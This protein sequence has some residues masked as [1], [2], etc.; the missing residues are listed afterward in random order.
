MFRCNPAGTGCALKPV[1]LTTLLCILLYAFPA[2]AGTTWDGGGAN[3]LWSTA[4]NWNPDGVPANNGTASLAFAGSTRLAPDMDANWNINSL[5]FNNGAGAFTLSSTGGFVL[6]IQ[7]GGITNNSASTETIN[8]AITLGAAQT[9]GATSGALSFGGNITTGGFLLT[10]SGVSN[11]AVNGVISGTGGLAKTGAGTLSLSGTNTY[12]GGTT[13]NAGA[14]S[15]SSN[16]NLGAA[17]GGLT[18]NGGTLDVTGNVVGTR[19][20]TMTG[21]G[22]F[23]VALG[24]S[25]EQSG[26]VSGNGNLTLTSFGTLILSGSGSNGTGLTSIGGIL[27]LRGTVT[28]GTGNLSFTTGVLELGNGNFT[29]ALGA[30]AGQ[31]NMSTATNGAGFAAYGT[32]RIVNLGGAGAIVTWGSGSFLA[33]GQVLYL[34]SLTSDH[35]VDFQNGINLNGGSRSIQL[36]A[37]VGSVADGKLSGVISG[38]GASNLS[39][40]AV[41][42]YGA[43]SVILSNGGNSYAGT[44]TV[45][46][47]TLILEASASG[48]AGNTVLGSGASDVLIGN[49]TGA[50]DAGLVTNNAVTVSRILRAQSGNTGVVTIGGTSASTSTFSGSL[51]LGTNAGTGKGVTLTSAAGGTTTFS[52]VVQDPTGVVGPGLVRTNGSGTVVLS[53]V[54][55]YAGGTSIDGGTLSIS[56]SA[57]L[58]ANAGGIAINAGTLSITSGFSTNR[59]FTLGNTASTLL[60]N[61]AQTLTITSAVGGTGALNKNGGGT[62]TL[63]GANTYTGGSIINGGTLIITSNGNLG[64]AAGAVTLNAAT[65]DV[66]GTFVSTRNFT[67]GSATSTVQVDPTFTF[68]DSGIF[69]G[70]GTLN[71]TGTGTLVLGG[72]NTY[73]G[74]TNVT[75]G[76]LRNGIANVIPD[77]SAVTVTSGATY[78]LNSFS[79]TVGSLSGAGTVTSGV[80]GTPTLTAGGENTSTLFSG[81]LQ[82]GSGTVSFTKSGT[83]T[84]TLSGANTYSG[85]T[86][87]SGGILLIQNSAALGTTAGGTTVSSG[88][89]LELQSNIAVAAEPLTLNGSGVSSFGAL[90]NLS[91]NN[92]LA[93]T[94]TLAS[95]STIYSDSGTLTLTGGIANG[96]FTVTFG[97]AGNISQTNPVSGTGALVKNDSGTLTLGGANTY[98]G[99]TTINGGT[100]II[101]STGNLGNTLGTATINAATLEAAATFTSSRNFILGS[102]TSTVQVDPT[103]TFTATGIISGAG[104]LNKTGA[105]TMVLSGLNLFS[106]GTTVTA[107]TLQLSAVNRLLTT[108]G[109]TISGGTFDLQTFGQTTSSVTLSSGAITGSGGGTLTGSSYTLQ[110]GTV[111]AILAGNGTLTKNTAG[112]VTLSGANTFTGSTTISAGL[113]Q[114]NTNNALGTTASGTTVANGAA[115]QLNGVNYSTAEPLTLNGSGI[116]NGGALT[117]TG[118]STF[119]GPINAATNATINAGGG[120]LTLTGGISKNGTTLTIAGGGTV[121]ITANGITGAAANSDLIVD[122]TTVVLSAASSY[123]GPTTIQN[124]GTLKL[125]NSNVLPTAPQTALTINTSSTLDLASF[126]GSVASLTGDSTATVKNSVIGGTST[127]TITPASGLT[128]FAGIIAGTNGGAQGN[129]ALQ[130]TGAGTLVLTGANT[131]SGATTVSGGTLTLAAASGSALASTS[132]LTVNSGGTLL[133]GASNQINNTATITLAGGT[134]AKGNFSE[135]SATAP[136]IGMGTL[137]L[138][139]A[140]SQIDFGSGTTGV[141]NFASFNPG[142]YALMI[143][144]WTGTPN[145]AGN[146]STDRLIFGSDQ[147]A[148]LGNFVFSGFA[149]GALEINLGN[150]YYEITPVPETSTWFAGAFILGILALRTIRRGRARALFTR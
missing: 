103:F 143:A 8:N 33:A 78:D 27:S 106:G 133:L 80:A 114:V 57:N 93:G 150:G 51:F 37:G 19:A 87:V 25:M 128:T 2:L 132:S 140:G 56:Q 145:V 47:G 83:G 118:T 26:V 110:S 11:T 10:I 92:S 117:N 136:G 130:K 30:G 40:D 52:G 69:S 135:G 61:P 75:A 41:P 46:A 17:S 101:T 127:L 3:N 15:I 95:A 71:K 134:F 66:A 112:T 115:L 98:S 125:G 34:G 62:L 14:V 85:L 139:A 79:E 142:T 89:T 18:F 124:S 38:T 50:Y 20:V 24:S 35:T 45:N 44:T 1:R 68:T 88:A 16:G 9:W 86:T 96:G 109:L 63:G 104:T 141:L 149:P 72:D 58:G 22:T 131:L 64:A 138:T 90:R 5:T 54:N 84:L 105:G 6:T 28:L 76:T 7:G 43:G 81:V 60:I 107:G 129:V 21:A 70:L 144:N 123:N 55:T 4:N 23:D 102:A 59:V 77:S 65:L 126:S 108:A 111:S 39:I 12:S 31:V 122:G 32:N 13:F 99:G 42:T 73:T 91:G 49:T 97:G 48:T 29:R 94:I 82:N 116:S 119:G 137:T 148:N 74:A 113:L 36:L 53:G 100:T 67:L 146:G 120:A 121:N 147:F